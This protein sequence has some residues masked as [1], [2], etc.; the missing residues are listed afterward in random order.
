VREHDPGQHTSAVHKQCFT[1]REIVKI[2]DMA[3]WFFGDLA[4]RISDQ[5]PPVEALPPDAHPA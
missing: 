2:A 1:E 4:V 5:G 3:L